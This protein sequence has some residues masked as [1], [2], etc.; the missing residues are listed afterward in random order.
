MSLENVDSALV[1]RL[2]L[3]ESSH[4]TERGTAPRDSTTVNF[5]DEALYRTLDGSISPLST[6]AHDEQLPYML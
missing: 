3:V 4:T 6:E 1:N 2:T 5:M